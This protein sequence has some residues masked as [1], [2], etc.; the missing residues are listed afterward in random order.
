[1]DIKVNQLQQL[2]QVEAPRTQEK[3]GEDFKFTL[4][5]RSFRRSFPLL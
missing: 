4:V 5:S 2:T 3:T 1:M